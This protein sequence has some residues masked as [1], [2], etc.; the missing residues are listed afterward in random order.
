[1]SAVIHDEGCGAPL[2]HWSSPTDEGGAPFW[3][4]SLAGKGF[5]AS[6]ACLALGVH[7][8]SWTAQPF[9]GSLVRLH[10]TCRHPL[11]AGHV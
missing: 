1:M 4:P 8:A 9:C 3:N 7:F 5:L 11:A 10:T 6:F 2:R